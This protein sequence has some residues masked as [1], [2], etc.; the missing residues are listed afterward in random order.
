[1]RIATRIR[2]NA[3]AAEIINEIKQ[4]KAHTMPLIISWQCHAW[5]TTRF[6]WGAWAKK[7]EKRM[8]WK[9]KDRSKAKKIG[10]LWIHRFHCLSITFPVHVRA[11]PLRQF[12]A[13]GPESEKT[14]RSEQPDIVTLSEVWIHKLLWNARP[15]NNHTH[16]IFVPRHTE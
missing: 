9:D 7:R 3:C 4:T 13:C 11:K 6:G 16:N 8:R 1:M 12:R 5:F 10:S 14:N 15:N 2:F